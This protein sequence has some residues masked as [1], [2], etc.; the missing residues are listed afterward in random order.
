MVSATVDGEDDLWMATLSKLRALKLSVDP[1]GAMSLISLGKMDDQ[2]V[3]KRSLKKCATLNWL[4]EDPGTL[5]RPSNLSME[6]E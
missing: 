3:N 6:S 1:D 4:S 2:K 5:F